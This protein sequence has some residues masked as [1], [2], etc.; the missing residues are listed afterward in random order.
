MTSI[1]LWTAFSEG[2][3]AAVTNEQL[4]NNTPDTDQLALIMMKDETDGIKE[5]DLEMGQ[6]SE[7]A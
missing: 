7:R 2:R 6:N 4:L 1:A 5:K 3:P